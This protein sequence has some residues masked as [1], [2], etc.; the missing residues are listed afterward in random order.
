MAKPVLFRAVP[1]LAR[2]HKCLLQL[3]SSASWAASGCCRTPGA[4]VT[5]ALAMRPAQL[6]TARSK[7]QPLL[8]SVYINT[9]GMSAQTLGSRLWSPQA[10]W[11][12]QRVQRGACG[13]ITAAARSGQLS[14]ATPLRQHQQQRPQQQGMA[15]SH[16]ASGLAPALP[17]MC[18]QVSTARRRCAS[19]AAR[20]VQSARTDDSSSSSAAPAASD[21]EASTSGSTDGE[22]ES[23]PRYSP[24]H[25][26][27]Q[28]FVT[29]IA[30][31]S[32]EET[33]KER[34]IEV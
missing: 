24:L 19:H 16:P 6:H 25:Q 8:A 7:A 23:A 21:A 5:S 26:N 28:E 17:S 20:A 2:G 15:G 22:E 1:K 27:V 3:Y 33:A 34:V 4:G 32:S 11:R 14:V 10:S 12:L 30:P 13:T 18:R 29:R 31:T 9:Y